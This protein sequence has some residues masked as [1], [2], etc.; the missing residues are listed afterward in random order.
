MAIILAW[1]SCPGDVHAKHIIAIHV[2]AMHTSQQLLHPRIIVIKPSGSQPRA[3]AVTAAPDRASGRQAWV[4]LYMFIC[5]RVASVH[6]NI[7]SLESEPQ[8]LM[9]DL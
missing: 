6:G 1:C 4:L 3:C 9:S 8:Q 5:F 7:S 2:T